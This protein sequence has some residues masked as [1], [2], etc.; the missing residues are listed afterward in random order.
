MADRTLIPYSPSI[1][2]EYIA[3]PIPLRDLESASDFWSRDEFEDEVTR[4]FIA[5]YESDLE[6]AAGPRSLA[7]VSESDFA[8][9]KKVGVY[10]PSPDRIFWDGWIDG[11]DGMPNS[12]LVSCGPSRRDDEIQSYCRL[13]YFRRLHALPRN[14][15]SPFPGRI[16]PYEIQLYLPQGE[17]PVKGIRYCVAVQCGVAR[18]TS[19]TWNRREPESTHDKQFGYVAVMALQMVADSRHAWSIS[20]VTD[21]A[22]VTVGAYPEAVKSLLYMR[23]L[24]MTASGRKRPIL[25]AVSAHKRRMASGVDVD[26]SEFLRGSRVIEMDGMRYEVSAPVHRFPSEKQHADAMLA[27]REKRNA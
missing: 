13:T 9:A 23:S 24:P 16:V 27:E 22:R 2:V 20:A 7:H 14:E 3:P 5:L 10:I 6:H 11:I 21:E 17:G 15:R 25:H 26:I 19:A 12:A 8:K 4:A 18:C 1:E